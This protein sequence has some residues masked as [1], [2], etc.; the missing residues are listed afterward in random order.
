[1]SGR[2]TRIRAPARRSPSK[3]S[4]AGPVGAVAVQDDLHGHAG[5]ELLLQKIAQAPRP[6][7]EILEEVI[8]EV[9][10]GSGPL[11]RREHRL[12]GPHAV[13]QQIHPV[14]RSGRLR[15]YNAASAASCRPSASPGGSGRKAIFGAGMQPA[16][17]SPEEAEPSPSDRPLLVEP[18]H[19]GK[20]PYISTRHIPERNSFVRR[21]RVRLRHS[22]RVISRPRAISASMT[23]SAADSVFFPWMIASTS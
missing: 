11:H 2:K 7:L 4:G 20:H 18:M 17:T 23:L 9:D 16:R 1:M 14:A 22:R 8:F 3:K 19:R 10:V 15:I 21:S 5:P 13:G 6:D 12:E